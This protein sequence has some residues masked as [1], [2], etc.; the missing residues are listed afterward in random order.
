MASGANSTFRQ[1][2]IATGI[3]GLGS[4]FQSQI[5]HKTFSCPGVTPAGQAVV[6]HGGAALQGA[7]LGGDVHQAA[8]AI[9]SAAARVRAAR[10][11]PG[12]LL[13][14]ARTPSWSSARSSPSWVDRSLR[15]GAAAGLHREL[16][17]PSRAARPRTPPVEAAAPVTGDRRRHGRAHRSG[18]GAA[19][20]AGPGTSGPVRPS[21]TPPFV[22]SDELG[23]GERHHGE[24][25]ERGRRGPGHHL[26][27]LPRQ[28]RSDHRGHRRQQHVAPGR[29]SLRR[30]A[31]AT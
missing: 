27:A 28:G 8:A 25:G 22:S 14:H 20:P 23:Y 4:V 10:R 18:I 24:R 11:L 6:A 30:P 7:I 31:P 26:P 13:L 3:A 21:P 17:P 9:P 29:G 5:Q 2:G 15:A 12:R 16:A 19:G 1:V